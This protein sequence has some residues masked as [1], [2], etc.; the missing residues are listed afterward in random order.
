[1]GHCSNII[2]LLT[3]S[4]LN[5]TGSKAQ[6]TH[7]E[8]RIQKLTQNI[9][10]KVLIFS[11]LNPTGSNRQPTHREVRILKTDARYYY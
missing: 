9:T 5:P 4:N 11:N 10:I 2:K 8:V 1:M 6:P 7:R 3:F